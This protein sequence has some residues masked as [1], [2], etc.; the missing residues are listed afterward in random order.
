MENSR[1][2]GPWGIEMTDK[3]Q[4]IGPMR[5]DGV[6]INEIVCKVDWDDG[7]THELKQR[8]LAN[9]LLISGA[10]ELLALIKELFELGD[11]YDGAI[12]SKVHH[13]VDFTKWKKKAEAAILKA[14]GGAE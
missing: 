13:R 11:F 3:A 10:P 7:Y 12:E 9:A 2:K 8:L 4:W 5:P 6:K 1:T 14:T